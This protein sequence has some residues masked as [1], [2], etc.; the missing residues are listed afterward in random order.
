LND[1]DSG[2]AATVNRW[3]LNH[4]ATVIWVNYPQKR[5]SGDGT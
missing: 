5:K 2:K 4:G 1:F 3:A